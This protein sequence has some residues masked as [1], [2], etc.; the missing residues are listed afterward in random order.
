MSF[1]ILLISTII[2]TVI[3]TSGA[4]YS[5]DFSQ[6]SDQVKQLL[7]RVADPQIRLDI[8]R[9]IAVGN[10]S[11]M[12]ELMAATDDL[13][14][15]EQAQE[16]SQSTMEQVAKAAADSR[17]ME[18]N[19]ERISQK[20][21]DDFRESLMKMCSNHTSLGYQA[22]KSKMYTF[23]DAYNGKVEGVYTGKLFA[24]RTCKY[25][26]DN[27]LDGEADSDSPEEAFEGDKSSAGFMN[28]EH[29]W[30][31]SFFEKQEPMRS[32]IW[33]LYPTDSIANGTRGSYPFGIVVGEP[34]WSEGGSKLGY[35]AKGRKVFEPRASHRGNLARSMFY[36]SVRYN[37]P[38]DN[39]QEA[40]FRKWNT[41]DP[42]DSTEKERANRIE[43]I[44]HNRN[45]F[46][47]HP[48]YADKIKDF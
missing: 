45:P 10:I 7:S 3:L 24:S 39:L 40:T 22:A 19:Y 28:C 27:G 48:E 16:S 38:I 33:H 26:S 13:N 34:I 25:I 4:S 37:D 17:I 14:L 41:A 9:N 32:D 8:E 12:D 20:Q 21:G 30:P 31:Q 2:L 35:D 43:S 29:S 1:K 47:D 23:I 18:R 6:N 42:V 5:Q 46:I 11:S 36:F 15:L 44:Q